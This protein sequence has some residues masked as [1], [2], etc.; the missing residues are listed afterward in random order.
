MRTLYHGARIFDGT[1]AAPGAGDVVVEDGRIIAVGT[2]LDGDTGVDLTG[3]ALLP[4]LID[5]HVHVMVSE[6]DVL[7][8]LE[9]P[10]SL[11]YYSAA[12]N[13]GL[14]LDCGLTTVRD[15]AGAD[16]GTRR[17]VDLGLVRG[18][19]LRIAVTMLSQTGGHADPWLP[20]GHCVP[21]LPGS[22]ALPGGV[23]DGVDQMRTRVRELVRAG[24]D[25]VKVAASGG[26]MSPGTDPR[27]PQFSPEELRTAVTEA[28]VAGL[29]V[30][31]HAQ[32]TAGVR[33]AVLAGV[34]SV[35]H[36]IYLDDDVVSMMLDRGTVL[37]PTLI[38][39]YSVLHAAQNGAAVGESAL[40]K[41]REVIEAHRDSFRRAVAAGVPVAMGTDAI[42]YP[43][44]RNLEEL[45]LMRDGGMSPAEVLV[46]AT[47]AAAS[48]LGLRDE[49]GTLEPGKRAD[50]VVVRG[51][52]LELD[53]LRERV[54]A[55]VKDG[56]L[57]AGRLPGDE[58]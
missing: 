18:P 24:A 19:R 40:L 17:A 33:N 44:G 51:D 49:L 3:H 42:G 8:Q 36:G 41:V 26:V 16:L 52:P 7:R 57:A 5:C 22:P 48:L 12:R 53:T 23:V 38:A 1:G 10:H 58:A 9:A 54:R 31:A 35:E 28:S 39:P 37:V 25:W 45:A 15:A 21:V 55:V 56:V 46:S 47:S 11:Q 4:G 50:L 14:L 13:L 34:R 32:A 2:G 30:M 20:S 29:G 43:H 27:R 6:Y